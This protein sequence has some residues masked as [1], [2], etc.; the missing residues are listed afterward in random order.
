[1]HTPDPAHG[2]WPM[3]SQCP[4]Q[5]TLDRRTRE[6]ER[7]RRG[8]GQRDRL[9]G[10]C[11]LPSGNVGFH[12]RVC[13]IYTCLYVHASHTHVHR[14]IYTRITYTHT[15][16]GM[17]V[18]IPTLCTHEV[19]R[20]FTHMLTCCARSR[21]HAHAFIRRVCVHTHTE[22]QKCMHTRRLHTHRRMHT[23]VAN[24]G[25]THTSGFSA[26]SFLSADKM[27]STLCLIKN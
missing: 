10:F 26:S 7:G 24:A 18:H 27:Q 11:P 23:R 1:M 19:Y 9:S 6:T 22:A 5:H 21:T 20:P 16:M 8:Q 13:F 17:Y 15:C 14:S 2:A 25:H 4:F 3:G 12:S